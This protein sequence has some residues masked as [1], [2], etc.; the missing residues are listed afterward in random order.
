ME[1][2]VARLRHPPRARGLRRRTPARS[3]FRSIASHV[4]NSYERRSEAKDYLW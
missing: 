3:I 4:L 1:R 2:S